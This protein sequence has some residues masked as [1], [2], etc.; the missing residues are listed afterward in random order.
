[1]VKRKAYGL[2]NEKLAGSKP[3]GGMPLVLDDRLISK[4]YITEQLNDKVDDTAF[5]SSWDAV[6]DIAPSKNA[7]YDHVNSLVSV[8]DV[9]TKKTSDVDSNIRAY[10][11]GNYA[12]GPANFTSD[13]AWEKL[14]VAGSIKATGNFIMATD[15]S[16][17]GP[18]SG[19]LTLHSTNGAL[20]PTKFMIGTGTAGVP[21]EVSLAGSTATA[22]DGTGIIQA[23]PDSGANLGIGANK[24]QARSGELVAEL[25]LNTTG[26][27]VTLGNAASTVTVT[28]DL[29]V[30]GAATTLNTA[31]LSVEDNE[32]TLNSSATGTPSANAGLRVERGDSPDAQL[33]WDESDNRWS[34]H[35]GTTEYHID[36]STHAPVTLGTNTE[37]ALSLSGQELSLADKFVQLGSAG[38]VET[39]RGGLIIGAVEDKSSGVGG[40]GVTNLKV[41]G[42]PSTGNAALI[43]DGYLEADNKAFNIEHPLKK[44]MRLVHGCLEG[45]EFGMYQRG[46]LKSN[47]LI[48]E[49][50]LP[51]Y[52]K[53]MVGDYTVTLTPHGN[54]N[55]WLEEKNKTMFK[56]KTSADA[57]DGP[58]AC[59]W[60]AIGRRMDAKLEVEIDAKE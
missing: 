48:E 29:V 6:T 14:Y 44:G 49:I 60:L 59:E 54:Y 12:I 57:I 24:I 15:G 46:T 20:L 38:T 7:V 58:W 30:S 25:E 13:S 51:E 1:M 55:V 10:K 23:G 33:I 3:R 56:I 35:N 42:G 32:I 34:V 17:I 5:G 41:F 11:T 45:P 43:V 22:A 50:S 52:W 8:S 2:E 16:T 47:L 18:T 19:S 21:L 37:T 26:G 39:M 53:A 9:W 36:H 31:A 4:Q 40:I 27:D 28:G